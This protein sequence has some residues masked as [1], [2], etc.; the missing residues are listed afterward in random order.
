METLNPRQIPELIRIKVKSVVSNT[1]IASFA[2]TS[3]TRTTPSISVQTTIWKRWRTIT[4]SFA[5]EVIAA[6]FFYLDGEGEFDRLGRTSR[7]C[8]AM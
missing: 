1:G 2:S 7:E 5:H 4:R 8:V 6:K 3:E